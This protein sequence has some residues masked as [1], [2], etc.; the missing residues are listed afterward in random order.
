MRL[1][2]RPF[3]QSSATL[4]IRAIAATVRGVT[5]A[6]FVTPRTVAA[7]A[8]EV[9][10]EVDV[11]QHVAVVVP[12]PCPCVEGEALVFF[13]S[14]HLSIFEVATHGRK[15]ERWGRCGWRRTL[16]LTGCRREQR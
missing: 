14:A 16:S 5:T 4:C 15:S 11:Q 8:I 12:P 13:I 3:R 6:F 7:M 2:S 9:V 10:V 1:S